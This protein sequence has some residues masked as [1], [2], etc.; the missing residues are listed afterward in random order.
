M[1][2]K[3]RGSWAKKRR[4]YSGH[5][6]RSDCDKSLGRRLS[7]RVRENRPRNV[8]GRTVKVPLPGTGGKICFKDSNGNLQP[9]PDSPFPPPG[10]RPGTAP[11]RWGNA[12]PGPSTLGDTDG[13]MLANCQSANTTVESLDPD[14]ANTTVEIRRDSCRGWFRDRR[15]HPGCGA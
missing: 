4:I 2:R 12:I 3:W 9:P 7:S 15:F 14:L 11:S 8:W 1:E 10:L 6:L 13:S 5:E